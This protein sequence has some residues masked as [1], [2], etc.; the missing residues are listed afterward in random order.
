MRKML[1]LSTLIVCVGLLL[2]GCAGK[3]AYTPGEQAL[4]D[5]GVTL[6]DLSAEFVSTSTAYTARC[7]A[8]PRSLS[9]ADC[10]D[11]IRF[12]Q[13]FKTDYSQAVADWKSAR[14]S[15]AGQDAVKQTVA[16]LRTRL[17]PYTDKSK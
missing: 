4:L 5:V 7:N 1:T 12:S 15:G 10:N 6:S 8:T 9:V 3:R 13:G 17:K 16:G 14:S 11:F 2:V